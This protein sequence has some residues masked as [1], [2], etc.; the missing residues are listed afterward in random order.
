MDRKLDELEFE[1]NFVNNFKGNDQVSRTPSETLDSLY[2]RAMPT[3]VSGPRLIA[4]SSELASA[5]GIDQ[6]AE[7]R[8]S[9]EILSGNRVNRT[10]IPYA[11]C[12]GG[13]QFGHWAN[14][15][16]DGRAITL[17]EISKG[18]Q[19]FE[20]QLKGAGQTAYSR[21]GDG[22]AVLRSSVR[23]FLMSEA[24]FYL[25]VPTTRALSLVDTGD[26][27]LRD[28]FYDGNSEYEN[29]AIVSRVAPSFLRFGN[30]QILYARGE[31]SNLENLLNWS[32][33]K[34]YPEI[35][36]QGDQK[37]VSFFREVSK[38]T[39]RM[40][41]EWMRVGFVHGVMNTDNMSILGLTID[42]GPFSFL[43]NFDPSFTP[44]TTDLPGR[45]YAFAKQ[46]S[47]ALW[48]L[49]RFA[50]SLMPLMQETNLLE[51]E[52]SNF[53]EY[54]TTDY[55]QMMSRKYG[56]SNLKTEEGEE[57]LDQMRS[58]LYDCKV[59]MTLF[60][61]Y[62]IDL[63]RGEASRE[64]VMNHFNECFYRELSESEQREFYNLIKV[65]KSFLEKDS[66]TTSESRQIMSEANPRFI[67][68]NYLLQK[69]SEE[70][71]DGDDTLFNEL[72]L[73]LKNPY[74]KGSDKFF[75]KRPK[76]AENKAGSSMLSCS[77]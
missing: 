4:Y 6:G 9:V 15:L 5:M 17:G 59:D 46:P 36:E 33:Q 35:K 68:R 44:N 25:G 66:L 64:E 45:R 50:E 42:Y 75:C 38:R 16:G 19:I 49:Q 30:F 1:N 77:S 24:M 20:L 61:Q 52:V 21:R 26:K 11:A 29:G 65:Y 12:Y 60:F 8:E 2:T 48:N 40:I 28:M 69:A 53:K 62:L 31:V 74:S 63:A 47:I 37:I 3:P 43:D 55:Y 70:L 56:L 72:F 32:V 58:L 39:S 10:M 7:T 67:L 34:F 73:A 27:V 13:F 14:Q 41:S 51:D 76:W 57:F 18:N 22:R 54:Y 71:E 23:E